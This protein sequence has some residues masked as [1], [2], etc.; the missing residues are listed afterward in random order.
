MQRLLTAI[1]DKVFPNVSV[2]KR[3]VI[4]KNLFV[5]LLVSNP[6]FK[7]LLLLLGLVFGCLLLVAPVLQ[8]FALDALVADNPDY[9]DITFL[10]A[11][12]FLVICLAS[13][14]NIVIRM[15]GAREGVRLV[16]ELSDWLYRQ[17]LS[18]KTEEQ[19]KHT[20]GETVA[21]L[22]THMQMVLFFMTDVFP[23]FFV[24][25]LPLALTPFWVA[26]FFDLNPLIIC[27]VIVLFLLLTGGLAIRSSALFQNYKELEAVRLGAINEWIQNIRAIKALNWL[28]SFEGRIEN[29]GTRE[30]NQ[31]YKMVLNVGVMNSL[32]GITPYFLSI[33]GVVSLLYYKADFTAGDIFGIIWIL[34]AFLIAPLRITPWIIVIALDAAT[35]LRRVEAFLQAPSQSLPDNS[36]AP[37]NPSDLV[38]QDLSLDYDGKQVL[39]GIDLNISQGSLVAIVGPIGSGKSQ[40]LMSLLGETPCSFADIS[41]G[42]K[43]LNKR[44][45][46]DSNIFG[47][48]PQDPFAMS[49]TL[50]EN[51]LFEYADK[52]LADDSHIKRSLESTNYSPD[53]K[54]MPLGI[55]TELGERGVNL[56]GGQ[57]QRLSLSRAHYLDRPVLLLDDTLSALDED[58]EKFIF[59]KLLRNGWS[60]K[61]RILVTHR[62]SVLPEVDSIIFLDA[63][64]ILYQGSFATLK[65]EPRFQDFIATLEDN[66][67]EG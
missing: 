9:A 64:E 3:G 48:V 13:F 63:G 25:F 16:R 12:S 54:N 5:G 34:G 62:L 10:F 39:R 43:S 53:L 24:S 19:I 33:A 14:L 66:N 60:K 27:G 30:L 26:Y 49:A 46:R 45:L 7:L 8:K 52:P 18:L 20:V 15:L 41:F 38:V 58:T 40:L 59:T 32:S 61:T 1:V 11:I 21:L 55:H 65:D 28:S 56:S 42:D 6:V 50:W 4:R 47:L 51:V 2:G 37:A 31:R 44:T 23:A 22:A 36:K 35:S 17:A 57:K 29:L 67:V